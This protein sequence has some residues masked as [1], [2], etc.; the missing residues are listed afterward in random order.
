MIK[1]IDEEIGTAFGM[2]TSYMD[3]PPETDLPYV[4]FKVEIFDDGTLTDKVSE[5]FET[6]NWSVSRN[7]K[8]GMIE[9]T[10]SGY[11]L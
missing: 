5:N 1:V 10:F 4:T 6:E 3:S 8:T 2:G 7:V 9:I 11:P